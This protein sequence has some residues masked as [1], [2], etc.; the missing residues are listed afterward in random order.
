[1]SDRTALLLLDLQ[2]EIVE[3][4]G[5]VG[6]NGL[7]RIV[8]E[9]GV[10]DHAKAV[11]AAAR[12]SN[13]AIAHVRLGYRAD[14]A[15]M[16]SVAPRLAKLRAEGGAILGQWGTEFPERVAPRDDELVVTKQC[17]NP[18]FN[19]GLL[20][21]LL[22]K[23]V[24]QLVIGGVVTNSVVE[25]TA[26]GADDAGFLVTVLEDC[27]AAPNPAWHQFSMENMMPLFG[28]VVSSRTL[29]AEM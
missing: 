23:G 13:W 18:F 7:A 3:P 21:W 28:R 29:L 8:Q 27:C 1:M 2:N 22:R 25:L 26:R 17:V 4:K 15:D 19:T 12:A 10:L 24:K 11:L 6:G 9:R 14:Y 16:L 5:K 20:T